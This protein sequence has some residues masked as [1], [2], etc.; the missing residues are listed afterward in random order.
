MHRIRLTAWASLIFAYVLA[1]ILL[2]TSCDAAA[3]GGSPAFGTS[4]SPGSTSTGRPGDAAASGIGGCTALLEARRAASRDY[5]RIRSQF[6]RSRW[7]DVRAAGVS[8]VELIVKLQDG[9]ADGYET[10]WFYQ[11][12][13]R[14][15]ARH[16]WKPVSFV[17]RSE[18]RGARPKADGQGPSATTSW[19]WTRFLTT[20]RP[21]RRPEALERVRSRMGSGSLGTLARAG[22]RLTA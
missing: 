3:S 11:R 10:V 22:R 12:L 5:P 14:A 7:P 8:Y 19:H 17:E 20:K 2:G 9:G 6:A 4:S 21:N 13:S 1:V 16:G 18:R 15:C